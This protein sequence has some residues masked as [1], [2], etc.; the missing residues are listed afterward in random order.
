MLVM[1]RTLPRRIQHQFVQLAIDEMELDGP[2]EKSA[3]AFLAH[4][5]WEIE[6]GD[7]HLAGKLYPQ[8]CTHQQTWLRHRVKYAEAIAF[9][10]HQGFW[11]QFISLFS[12]ILARKTMNFARYALIITF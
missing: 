7:D 9:H 1:F 3:D 2:A 4:S 11:L 10:E 12:K 6:H 8:G 5:A